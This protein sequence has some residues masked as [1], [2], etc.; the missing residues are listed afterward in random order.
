MGRASPWTLNSWSVHDNLQGLPTHWEWLCGGVQMKRELADISAWWA[1]P[2]FPLCACSQQ[3]SLPES[4][5]LLNIHA[6][7]YCAWF[8]SSVHRGPSSQLSGCCSVVCKHS[9]AKASQPICLGCHPEKLGGANQRRF[10]FYWLP[11]HTALNPS[12]QNSCMGWRLGGLP[13]SCAADHTFTIFW[14]ILYFLS[15]ISGGRIT[16]HQPAHIYHQAKVPRKICVFNLY[17]NSCLCMKI[18]FK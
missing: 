1:L 18:H 9:R 12:S 15:G 14:V 8:Y 13:T 6:L 10:P 5:S 4:P 7:T 3:P 16:E 11:W 17:K 2:K